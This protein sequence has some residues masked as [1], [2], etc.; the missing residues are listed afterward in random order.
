MEAL[1][2]GSDRQLL[3]A[4]EASLLQRN[5]PM[6]SFFLGFCRPVVSTSLG[7]RQRD[8]QNVLTL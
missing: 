5:E 3:A 6:S 1:R 8:T 2:T 4:L 7:V